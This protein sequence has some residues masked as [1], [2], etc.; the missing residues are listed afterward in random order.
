MFKENYY[1]R[2]QVLERPGQF[3]TPEDRLK[4]AE[5]PLMAW[6]KENARELPW[7][8]KPEAYR[9]WISEIML[10][11]TRVE[12]VK[13]YFER[14]ISELPTVKAL[15][16]VEADRLMKLWEGL[17][18]YSRARNL[19]KAAI[20]IDGLYDGQLPPSLEKLK[21]LPGI[22]SYTAGAVASIAY[23][24]PAPAVDGNVLR[25]VSRVTAS[26]ED[27]TKQSAKNKMEALIGKVIPKTD[28]G[29]YNQALIEI[30]ALVCVPNGSP[31]CNICPLASLC[32]ARIKG[33]TGELP[34][35]SGK[36]ER[37]IVQLTVCIIE[38]NQGILIRKREDQ[39]LLAGLYELPNAEGD[40]QEKDLGEAFGLENYEVLERL[41]AAKHIF[42]HVEWHMNGFRLKAFG[43][44]QESYIPV[45]EKQL[46]GEYPLPNAFKAYR[47][48]IQ[49]K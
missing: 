42:T 3:F 13:P 8:E 16:Q 15:A 48:L 40:L 44:L 6:Y 46:E 22:G 33:L 28:P 2:L 11:Q 21:K 36:K 31:H 41:P 20:E 19:K 9:V 47:K 4:A 37:K 27:I 39:G 10:Q 26:Y 17:G 30:G 5:K 7:R 43:K 49:W 35:K 24:I 25:V 1:D 23:G 38:T 14:F 45:K 32:L 18:Y 29:S 12:A 34:V